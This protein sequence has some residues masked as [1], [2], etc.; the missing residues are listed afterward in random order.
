MIEVD[1]RELAESPLAPE[2]KY[3]LDRT[4]AQDM[5]VAVH[6]LRLGIQR[7]HTGAFSEELLG[8]LEVSVSVGP[9]RLKFS[10]DPAEMGELVARLIRWE[11]ELEEPRGGA[12]SAEELAWLVVELAPASVHF[13][14]IGA[15]TWKGPLQQ[16]DSGN[17]PDACDSEEIAVPVRGVNREAAAKRLAWVYGQLELPAWNGEMPGVRAA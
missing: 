11:R 6:R 17:L 5:E 10:A 13:P 9:T 2:E 12:P 3:G 7:L 14:W 16:L 4:V 1:E 8:C 15:D